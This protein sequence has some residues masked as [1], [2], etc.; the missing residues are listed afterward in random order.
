MGIKEM[1][2]ISRRSL[3]KMWKIG[4]REEY[5]KER[6]AIRLSIV[7]PEML[8]ENEPFMDS[9]GS[10]AL[11]RVWMAM[12]RTKI[13]YWVFGVSE[14]K[15]TLATSERDRAARVVCYVHICMCREEYKERW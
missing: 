6:S 2:W 4:S 1:H 15:S 13:S 9:V 12:A 7:W 14:S 5:G 3:R 11:A 8:A 10:R